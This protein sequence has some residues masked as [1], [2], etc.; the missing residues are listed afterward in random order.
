IGWI[1]FYAL[2]GAAA[3]HPSMR[4]VSEPTA[5]ES[6][7]TIGSARLLMLGAATLLAPIAEGIQAAR[8]QPLDLPVA[9]G[10][11]I[12]LF[13]LAIVRMA[14]FVRD[15]QQSTMREHALL[16]AGKELETAT[17][18]EGIY[19]ATSR[20]AKALVGDGAVVH[21]YAKHSGAS[22]FALMVGETGTAGAG[23]DKFE[24]ARLDPETR[25]GLTGGRSQWVLPSS[26]VD[27]PAASDGNDNAVEYCSPVLVREELLGLLTIRGSRS[28]ITPL[29]AGLE[30]LSSQVALALE[31]AVLT[32]ELLVQQSEARFASLVKNSSDVIIL[33][34]RDTTIRYASP[35]S[36]SVLGFE[37]SELEGSRLASLVHAGDA[38]H[39]DSFITASNGRDR[40]GPFEFRVRHA[41][42]RYIFAEAL[43]TNLESDPNVGGIVLNV[44]DV[45]ERKSFE[46]QLAHQAFHD[47]LTGLANRALFQDRVAHAI[48]RR[49]RDAGPV[50]VLFVDLDDFK[51][52]ND[53]LGHAV[54]DRV[55][56]ECGERLRG[57]L[58]P[59]DT[60]AR[61]GGDEF[62]IL[63]EN[64]DESSYEDVAERI[65]G[66]LATPFQLD[67]RELLVRA[68]IGIATTEGGPAPGS[69][70]SRS[71]DLLR[72]ADLA[73]YIAKERGKARYELFEPTMHADAVQRL[74]LK[75]DMQHALANDEF[76][77]HY[78]PMIEI[79]TGEI[80]GFEALIRWHHP[81]RGTV[82]P[83]DFI[84]LAEETGLIMP[85]G[86]WVLQEACTFAASLRAGVD[87]A[88]GRNDLH[89]AVNLSPRQLQRPEIVDHVRDVLRDT[90]LPPEALIL[91][92]T[93][94][95][96]MT[97]M[98]VGI[99]RLNDFKALG[100]QLAID[101]FGT[102]YSSLNY[103]RQFPVDILKIDKS[104]V[105]GLAE[106]DPD[107]SLVAAVI[108][109]ARV[110]KLHAVAEGVEEADQLSRLRELDCEF[111]QG[112]L[113][114]RPMQG[115]ALLALLQQDSP[116][117]ADTP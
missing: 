59:A 111:A 21:F 97:D 9:L 95:A 1:T 90:G 18:R 69:H 19:Q 15:Q 22:P 16:Q 54:G 71:E 104:F 87:G 14:G 12:V 10:A 48:E 103:V 44:R 35:S 80:C 72:N 42:D 37:P 102:G 28:S 64:D 113:F 89:V 39:V 49:A 29:T 75:A 65:M 50:A 31:S 55:L 100:V 68:S 17:N 73:M 112:Y 110:M 27:S 96:M 93:E 60:P 81:T 77:L 79:T 53:S 33:L 88:A 45:S 34:D 30:A 107:S 76:E 32:E 52:I 85:I 114:A 61:I 26:R 36:A 83:L 70:D 92:I 74:E 117:A 108:E 6:S 47:V 91:E 63:L 94:S 106:E 82:A 11:T 101:D 3:L 23:G 38:S 86:R 40:S 46:E 116:T 115:A 25:E 8:H 20:A 66:A 98:N 13:V 41:D 7:P 99:R 56:K 51:T 58:R 2:F 5:A 78:Q 57:C 84:P 109:L 67:D 24:I 4:W 43:R 62:A 105:D